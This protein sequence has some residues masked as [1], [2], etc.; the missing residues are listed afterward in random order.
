M[1]DTQDHYAKG[2]TGT[3]PEAFHGRHDKHLFFVVDEGTAIGGFVFEGISSMFK[4]NGNHFWLTMLNPIDTTSAVYAEAESGNY[5]IIRLNALD[6]P[7]IDRGLRGLPIE[8]DGAV[9]LHQVDDWF[10]KWFEEVPLAD[11]KNGDLVWPPK[12]YMNI[13][14]V[15]TRVS[16]DGRQRCLRPGMEGQARV[17][18]LWPTSSEGQVWSDFSWRSCLRDLGQKFQKQMV[19]TWESVPEIGC[20]V[21]GGG[22]D[23]TEIVVQSGGIAL[24]HKVGAGWEPSRVQGAL[25]EMAKKW[26]GIYN[27]NRPPEMPFLDEFAVPI[28][29]DDANVGH[30]V[31]D[32]MKNEGYDIRGINSGTVAK[33]QSKYVLMRDQL[34]FDVVDAA[35]AGQLDFSRLSQKSLVEL[36]RQAMAVR[37]LPVPGGRRMI[38]KKEETRKVI[39]RSPDGMDALN[40]AFM[41]AEWS[42]APTTFSQT[43]SGRR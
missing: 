4:A 40:L 3:T 10:K 23:K 42:V 43:G 38:V 9:D 15:L 28:R 29:V 7:N 20:D 2:Y 41:P 21:A 24:E 11:E 12:E 6:H 30:A 37:W 33:S 25:I 32:Y 16:T 34:W 39:G 1:G 17:L 27:Q 22:G 36:K 8:I 31:V 5:T 26:I 19:L 13:P 35:K 18:G 14:D